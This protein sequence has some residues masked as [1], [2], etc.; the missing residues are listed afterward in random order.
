LTPVK[1]VDGD[2][3]EIGNHRIRLMGIDAPEYIQTCKDKHKKIYPCGINS[4]KY[5]KALIKDKTLT[6]RV[7]KK[8]QYERDLCT[9]YVGNIDIN[10]EMI[11]S[12]NAITY[13]ETPYRQEQAEAKHHKRGLWQGR[14]MQPRLFRRLSE[15]QKLN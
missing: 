8:D 15:Q 4:A 12:G 1:V 13:L 11:L 14:F 9:C 7:H 5:L 3:M 10:R 2:S 6:C